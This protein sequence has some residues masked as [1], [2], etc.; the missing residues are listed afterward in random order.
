MYNVLVFLEE[1]VY[2][3]DGNIGCWDFY[4]I[5]IIEN[6]ACLIEGKVSD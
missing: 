4:S 3:E 2:M 5:Y 1:R 6:R